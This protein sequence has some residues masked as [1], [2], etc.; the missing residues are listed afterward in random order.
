MTIISSRSSSPMPHGLTAPDLSG[1]V[2]LS[3]VTVKIIV[4]NTVD[5]AE[6]RVI[7]EAVW[8]FPAETLL[9]KAL[10]PKD[11]DQ[12]LTIFDLA[13]TLDKLGYPVDYE[14]LP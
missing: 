8:P 4:D 3:G 1:L 5:P 13:Q 2:T 9:I 10:D 14:E 11:G 12:T 6:L 7:E